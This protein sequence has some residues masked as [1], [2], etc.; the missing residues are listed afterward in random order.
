[1]DHGITI[2]D[3]IT[4]IGRD[5]TWANCILPDMSVSRQHAKIVEDTDGTFRVCDEKS[6]NGTFVGDDRVGIE[7]RILRVGD[8]VS[9]GR[10]TFEFK[11]KL[12]AQEEHIWARLDPTNLSN[13]SQ[14]IS[15]PGA[16]DDLASPPRL[17]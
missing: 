1:M 6:L 8:Q 16:T 15:P 17:G 11:E 2:R 4:R 3:E 12:N 9:F 14:L 5:A 13:D 10:Y 7:G